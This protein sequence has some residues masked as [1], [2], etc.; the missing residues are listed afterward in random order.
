MVI[1]TRLPPREPSESRSLKMVFKTGACWA[2]QSILRWPS[3]ARAGSFTMDSPIMAL[4]FEY[5]RRA[6]PQ[7]SETSLQTRSPT[8]RHAGGSRL[9]EYVRQRFR[10]VG[11]Q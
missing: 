8:C 9:S 7:L 6:E 4:L 5:V 3:G 10:P 11:H 1:A 2:T